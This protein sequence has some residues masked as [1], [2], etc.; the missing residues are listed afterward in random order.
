LAKITISFQ[1]ILDGRAH[2]RIP[3]V[4]KLL[5]CHWM[6]AP[7]VDRKPGCNLHGLQAEALARRERLRI[8]HGGSGLGKSILGGCEIAIDTMLPQAKIGV[9][10]A[11]YDHVAHEFEYAFN[12]LRKLFRGKLDS[13]FPRFMYRNHGNNRIYEIDSVWKATV[14]GFSTEADEGASLL[15]QEFTK[16][17]VGE[18]SHISTEL[19]QKRIARALD[20]SLM[21]RQIGREIGVLVTF[22]TP[23]GYEGFT[24]EE[25]ERIRRK[26][27]GDLS[28]FEL[29]KV[30]WPSTVWVRE[31]TVLEN[32]AYSRQ[33]FAARRASMTKQAFEEQWLGRMTFKTGLIYPEFDADVHVVEM[34]KADEIRG[35][36][37]FVGIDTGA[38]FG[39]VLVGLTPAHIAFV[40][41]NVYTQKVKIDDSALAVREMIE[42]VLGPVHQTDYVHLIGRIDRWIVDPASQHK[43]ELIDLLEIDTIAHPS[44]EQ[45]QFHLLP[46]IDILRRAIATRKLFVVDTC[47]DLL[48]QLRKY[49]WKTTKT[50]GSKDPVIRE[51]RKDYD[52]LCDALRFAAVPL[53]E[54]GPLLEAPDPVT[55]AEAWERE[56]KDS[57][58]GPLK[59]AM[60][61]GEAK[62]GTWVGIS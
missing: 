35:M 34:P 53:I 41:G 47:S 30:D 2:L 19:Y 3:W 56:R 29:G 52:H 8:V 18:G 62:G 50:V 26:S 44:R 59:R 43:L 20:R 31:A 27:K 36:R 12:G 28:S 24:A 57:V 11:R 15:G 60:A 45:G 33:T 7:W 10:A 39:A 38:Y 14:R 54:E 61:A 4:G 58:F 32:P 16:I 17:V 21:N 22:T 55:F 49:V 9:V 13:A 23:K 40:L 5:L 42:E 46:T 37:L 48:D 51:P 25:V 6:G 1:D